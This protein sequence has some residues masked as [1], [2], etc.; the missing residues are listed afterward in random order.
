MK[1]DGDPDE[2]KRQSIRG[3]FY[4]YVRNGRTILAAW[5]K[6][7]PGPMSEK[8]QFAVEKFSQ[9]ATGSKFMWS[10]DQNASRE[11]TKRTNAL[12]RDLLMMAAYGRLGDFWLTDGSRI[13]SMASLY[14]LTDLLDVVSY[15]P[16]S[17][18][19]RGTD[20]WSA[21]APGDPGS[22]LKMGADGFPQWVSASGGGGSFAL[23]DHQVDLTIG[24]SAPIDITGLEP[25]VYD[26]QIRVHLSRETGGLSSDYLNIQMGDGEDPE[27]FMTDVIFTSKMGAE[28]TNLYASGGVLRVA[29]VRNADTLTISSIIDLQLRPSAPWAMNLSAQSAFWENFLRADVTYPNAPRTARISASYQNWTLDYSLYAIQKQATI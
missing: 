8:Q 17:L 28:S 20:Y 12:P 10:A 24:P 27:T 11:M 14:D 9:A 29:Q 21:L 4:V 23:I 25:E 18:L 1:L 19:F 22:I 5:P 6:K 16:G 13:Y 2:V 15:A 26:Y 3:A 7:R